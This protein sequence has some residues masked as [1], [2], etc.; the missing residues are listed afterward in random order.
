[1]KTK[2]SLNLTKVGYVLLLLFTV[3]SIFTACKKNLVINDADQTLLSSSSPDYLGR[4]KKIK[5]LFDTQKLDGKLNTKSP[6]LINW[7]P[8]WKHP[9]SQISND[10]TT[11]VFYNLNANLKQTEKN[12]A[13]TLPSNAYL[14][15]KNEKEFFKG[16]YFADSTSKSITKN[17]AGRLLLTNLQTKQSFLIRYIDGKVVDNFTKTQKIASVKLMSA[18]GSVSYWEQHCRTEMVNCVFAPSGYTTCGG[19]LAVEIVPNCSWPSAHCGVSWYL[20]DNGEETICENIWFPD[21][22]NPIEGGGTGGGE[23][24]TIQEQIDA[25]KEKIDDTELSE[26]ASKI[27]DSIQ[28]QSSGSVVG[29]IHRF[30]GVIPGYDW[31]IKSGTLPISINGRTNPMT[32][33]AVTVIDVNKYA[34]GTDLSLARTIM[35]EAV[36]AYLVSY[37]KNDPL[38]ANLEY[39]IMLQEYTSLKNPDLNAVHHDEIVRQFKADIAGSLTEYGTARGYTF[40]SSQEKV[41]FYSDMAWGGLSETRAFK[42]LSA[43]EKLRIENTL[44]IEQYGVNSNGD[45]QTK[46]GRATGC[47]AN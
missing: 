7:I 28:M 43:A 11:Y 42:A 2:L 41:Q 3:F 5:E 37:F 22:P 25:F 1:M 46:K 33:G 39:S 21:P 44:L 26:C 14:I 19:S 10:S 13:R 12:E 6:S 20:V 27:L 4:L 36:H 47:P 23:E 17:F 35:H 34:N 38:R 32:G 8:D 15:V 16:I 30:A 40:S 24:P 29:I 31:K 9:I 45:P 18:P